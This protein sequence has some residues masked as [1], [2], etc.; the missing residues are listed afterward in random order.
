MCK[1]YGW[2]C[3]A[4]LAIDRREKQEEI[5]VVKIDNN[6]RP[7]SK[8]RHLLQI[9]FCFKTPCTTTFACGWQAANT[10]QQSN[11]PIT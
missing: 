10:G 7:Q 6:N 3:K 1:K 4:Y 2:G 5:P 8:C 11:S 9:T